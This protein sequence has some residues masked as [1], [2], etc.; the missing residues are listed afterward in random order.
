MPLEA[1]DVPI[2]N[3][4]EAIR[5][6]VAEQLKLDAVTL[7]ERVLPE[8]AHGVLAKA[9]MGTDKAKA[10]HL[11]AFKLGW[12]VKLTP[13]GADVVNDVLY[14]GVIELGRRPGRPGPPL[15]PILEWV[16]RKVLKSDPGMLT[17]GRK[18]KRAM[19][20]KQREAKLKSIAI[21]IRN[22]IHKKG[23]KPRFILRAALKVVPKATAAA[24]KRHLPTGAARGAG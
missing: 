10:V 23:T 4:G 6:L 8:V 2:G 11:G 20:P 17:R 16:R 14:A 21:A 12:A 24:V 5:R 9:I 13:E 18:S 22:S 7:R 19:T 15:A 3:V 1:W